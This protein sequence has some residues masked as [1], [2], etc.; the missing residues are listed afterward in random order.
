[1]RKYSTSYNLLYTA[2]YFGRDLLRK[3]I[4]RVLKKYTK[5]RVLDVGGRDFFLRAKKQGM[6]FDSW[7]A[8]EPTMD[9]Y[10]NIDDPQYKFELGDGCNLK[11]KNA[12]F[13]TIINLHVLEHVFE[14]IKMIKETS[15]VLKPN[16]HAIF[17][18]PNA[19]TLH[20]A[21][22]HYYNYTRFWI[23][24]VMKQNNLKI[25]LLKPLGGLWKT[26]AA[27]FFYFFLK[28]VR[29]PGMTT[30]DDKR[31]IFFY[32]LFP[33]AAVYAL[34]SIPLCLFLS[35]GDLTEDPNDNL[36]VVKK[37]GN[38]KKKK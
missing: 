6:K 18:I 21:P 28:S 19:A 33:F 4:F 35:L 29:I 10:Y 7:V 2:L 25:V 23:E 27:R 3:D 1:M 24:E 14:P 11:Y 37:V 9:E 36:V 5:G 15:R 34:I 31:T 8:I 22:G 26:I 38:E 30:K 12:T 17:L 13:D 32:V 16:G 20:M